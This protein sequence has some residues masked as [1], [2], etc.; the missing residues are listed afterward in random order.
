MFSAEERRQFELDGYLVFDTGLPHDTLH[1]ALVETGDLFLPEAEA[2]DT[3]G[4]T[5][6]YRD[7]RRLQD[8][9]KVSAAVKRIATD[10]GILSALEGLYE[11]QALPFQTLNFK[12]GS[13]Q[14]AHSDTIHFNSKPS[15]YMCGVWVALEDIDMDNG[16]VVYYPGS[17]R[18][19]ELTMRD[20][21]GGAGR[22]P[23]FV[24]FWLARLTRR[25]LARPVPDANDYLRYEEHVADLLRSSGV[26]PR[27]ATIRKGQAL[28]WAANLLHG[29][30][31]R[32]D[33][34]RTRHSQATHYFLEGC[35]YFTPLH[36]RG[37]HVAWRK[38]RRIA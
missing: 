15:G 32:R 3:S 11:R 26:A 8:A 14:P 24:D 27:H 1:A 33:R 6:V 34:S 10:P 35:R 25:R 5:V 20:V 4:V 31:L 38:P 36:T 18:L 22:G 21:L 17:H 19:P 37:R 13:E 7:S 9:W 12:V 16:P 29:G 30:S 23:S 2:P 28:L